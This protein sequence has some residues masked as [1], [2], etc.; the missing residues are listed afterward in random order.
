MPALA[1]CHP[2]RQ[3]ATVSNLVVLVT[4]GG[5]VFAAAGLIAPTIGYVGIAA[6]LFLAGVLT[7]VNIANTFFWTYWTP[8]YLQLTGRGAMASG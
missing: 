8:V 4:L 6:L 2:D 1:G 7:L 5:L 3:R